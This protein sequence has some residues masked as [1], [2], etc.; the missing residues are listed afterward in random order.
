MQSLLQQ[1]LMGHPYGYLSRQRFLI[2]VVQ[3]LG[4]KRQGVGLNYLLKQVLSRLISELMRKG[5]T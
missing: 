4:L 1:F 3:L 5:F 2:V